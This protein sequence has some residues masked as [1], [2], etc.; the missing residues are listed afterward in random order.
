MRIIFAR[1]E[2]RPSAE[3]CA[4]PGPPDEIR[5]RAFRRSVRGI[6]SFRLVCVYIS[7]TILKVTATRAP[8]CNNQNRAVITIIKTRIG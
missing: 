3:E 2:N 5:R 1:S 7:C 6:P 4:P 8:Y